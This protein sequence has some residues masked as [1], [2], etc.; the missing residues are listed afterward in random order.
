MKLDIKEL[1]TLLLAKLELLKRYRIVLFVAFVLALYGYLALQTSKAVNVEPAP[2]TATAKTTPHIDPT[3]VKQLQQ[4]QDNS[5]S[6]KALFND[7]RTN[8]FQ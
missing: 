8:P 3:V 5:V 7:A 6:V 2:D 4:L 1:P